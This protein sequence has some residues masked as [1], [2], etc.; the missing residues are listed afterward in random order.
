[1]RM[2]NKRWEGKGF[3][4]LRC[5]YLSLIIYNLTISTI[6]PFSYHDL[7]PEVF[8]ACIG[9]SWYQVIRMFNID[10]QNQTHNLFQNL[11]FSVLF[12]ACTLH[13]LQAP[14][15]SE[16]WSKGQLLPLAWK[17]MITLAFL[18]HSSV[19]YATHTQLA[20]TFFVSKQ[21]NCTLLR[22]NVSIV[23][24]YV[25]HSNFSLVCRALFLSTVKF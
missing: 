21:C 17:T 14:K 18:G 16:Y 25:C 13:L 23:A 22:Q 19:W 3:E 4:N 7:I 24:L 15:I 1:M 9:K 2:W 11:Y 8:R 12:Y 6:H 10:K 5:I 20:A